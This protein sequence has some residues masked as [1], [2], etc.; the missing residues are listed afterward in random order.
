MNYR[1]LLLEMAKEHKTYMGI[2]PAIKDSLI[3]KFFSERDN[4]EAKIQI[5]DNISTLDFKEF[6]IRNIENTIM[7]EF[8]CA[9]DDFELSQKTEE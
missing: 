6:V 2:P 4:F 5:N 3:S 8:Y 7:Y 1:T 9:R